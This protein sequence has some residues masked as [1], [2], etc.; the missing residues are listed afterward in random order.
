MRVTDAEHSGGPPCKSDEV[1]V[2]RMEQRERVIPLEL[3][4]NQYIGRNL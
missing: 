3:K 1:P 2:M 4:I